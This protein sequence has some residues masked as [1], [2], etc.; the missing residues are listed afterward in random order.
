MLRLTTSF[1]IGRMYLT[2]GRVDKL[3]SLV[4]SGMF[5]VIIVPAWSI[6]MYPLMEHLHGAL[7]TPVFSS[8]QSKR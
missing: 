3:T 4:Y 2:G 8:S 1:G 7:A 6:Y 5:F